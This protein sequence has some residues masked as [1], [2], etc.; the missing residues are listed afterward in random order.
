MTNKICLVEDIFG[1]CSVSMAYNSFLNVII[2]IHS[3]RHAPRSRGLQQNK[4]LSRKH[5][6]F[7]H[8]IYCW[9]LFSCHPA[10]ESVCQLFLHDTASGCL[11][12]PAK[13][14]KPWEN[15]SLIY[16]AADPPMATSDTAIN[17]LPP[18]PP[19]QCCVSASAPGL[20]HADIT[21]CSAKV[22]PIKHN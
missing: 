13:M 5:L 10:G 20:S 6:G 4:A 15:Q 22:Y 2:T 7:N 21:L 18:P 3:Q 12:L 16:P 14:L 11:V 9:C 19:P 17:R 8:I 1:Q